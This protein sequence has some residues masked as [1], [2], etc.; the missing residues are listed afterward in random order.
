MTLP[1][2]ITMLLAGAAA[3]LW[4]SL[5]LFAFGSSIAVIAVIFGAGVLGWLFR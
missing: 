3:I 1:I 5:T 4:G 2:F